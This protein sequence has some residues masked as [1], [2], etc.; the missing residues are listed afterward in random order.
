M[1]SLTHLFMGGRVVICGALK[2]V[3]PGAGVTRKLSGLMEMFHI[4]ICVMVTS[5]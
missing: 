3:G 1:W 2:N 5:V 4:L